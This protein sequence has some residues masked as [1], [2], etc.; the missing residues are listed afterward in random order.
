MAADEDIDWPEDIPLPLQALL[1]SAEEN[2]FLTGPPFALPLGDVAL[3][4][5]DG[6]VGKSWL[7][8]QLAFSVASGTPFLG[9]PN[10][11]SKVLYLD[12]EN[13]RGELGHRARSLAKTLE[14]SVGPISQNLVIQPYAS[15]GKLLDDLEE[16][17]HRL[18]GLVKPSLIVVDGW[19]AAFGG[20]PVNS[21]HVTSAFKLLKRLAGTE[22]AVLVLTHVST[23]Q[24]ARTPSTGGK[25]SSGV[26]TPAGNRFV[27]HFARATYY[28]QDAG[29]ARVVLRVG[30]ENLGIPREDVYLQKI[31]SS[32][33][34]IYETDKRFVAPIS[35]DALEPKGQQPQSDEDR[36]LN[37]IKASGKEI[38]AP[39]LYELEAKEMNKSTKT[40]KRKIQPVLRRLIEQ[41]KVISRPHG[42]TFYVSA[43][44]A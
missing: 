35:P 31:Q 33:G 17:V 8:L 37:I 4:Y 19:Q 34:I 23:A 30:K 10:A 9:N 15:T 26:P 41:G 14:V 20:D 13:S 3:L 42:N 6:G 36:I 22:R 29:K 16:S 40:A 2:R 44:D 25:R 43:V 39:E 12:F 28:L 5:G 1:D 21:E 24:L 32:D 27:Q 38:G 18:L 7:A 11:A